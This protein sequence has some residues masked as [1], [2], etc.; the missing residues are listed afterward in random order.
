MVNSCG[1][2]NA[3]DHSAT[4]TA[5]FVDH[6]SIENEKIISQIVGISIFGG[7]NGDRVF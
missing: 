4:M 7:Q 6:Q 3:L 5:L 1:E 2:T